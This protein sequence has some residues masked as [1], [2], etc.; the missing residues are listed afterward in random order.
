MAV[1]NRAESPERLPSAVRRLEAATNARDV[2][3]IVGCFA[4]DYA[5][6]TPAHPARGF[7]GRDQV[8]RNWSQILVALPNLVA[9]VTDW[10]RRDDDVWTE[11][12]MR[13]TRRDGSAH[14]MYGMIIFT[15]REEQIVRARFH[16]EP[17]ESGGPDVESA[18]R[19]QLGA[20]S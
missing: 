2:L 1:Q 10:A 18:V 12:L 14:E 16:L 17:V 9:T 3:A 6:L 4:E 11:W 13:G 20:P 5:N 15:V 7:V 8:Q 19:L